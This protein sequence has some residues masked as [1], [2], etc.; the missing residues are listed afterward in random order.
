MAETTAHGAHAVHGHDT[1]AG[2][3]HTETHQEHP[4]RLYMVVWGW[5]FILSAG[6]YMVDYLHVQG[7]LRWTLILI[8]MILLINK[9]D[10]MGEWANP[11]WA[12]VV[13][14]IA[15]VIIIG[16]TLAYVGFLV[17]GL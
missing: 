15:A 11:M 16:L 13:S 7:Y 1:L 9:R 17:K 8:F 14:W 12:N 3:V 10:L 6:S 2:P 4:I 5:L